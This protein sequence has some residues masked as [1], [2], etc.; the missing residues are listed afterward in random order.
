VYVDL[1][2]YLIGAR[3]ARWTQ[4]GGGKNMRVGLLRLIKERKTNLKNQIFHD[5]FV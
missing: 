4:I 3:Y 1:L 2:S 5:Y